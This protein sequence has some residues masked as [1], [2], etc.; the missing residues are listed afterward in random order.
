MSWRAV[1]NLHV[2]QLLLVS[3][4]LI[5]VTTTTQHHKI[6]AFSPHLTHTSKWLDRN[7]CFPTSLVL[8]GGSTNVDDIDASP[9]QSMLQGE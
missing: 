9:L 1:M 2:Y 3:S 5:L 6:D 4:A 8:R 7:T